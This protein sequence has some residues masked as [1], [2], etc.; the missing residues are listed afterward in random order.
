MGISNQ[1]IGNGYYGGD[2]NGDGKTDV[3]Q[4]WNNNNKMAIFVYNVSSG[5]YN[6][7]Y[8]KTTVH[9]AVH[10]T[11]L[12][13]DVNGDKKTDLIEAWNNGGRLNMILYTSNGSS[14]STGSNITTSNGDVFLKLLP[15]D[16]DGDGRTDIAQLWNNGG[17]LAIIIYKS[18]GSTYSQYW[19]G[20]TTHGTG[21][22]GFTSGDFNGDGRTDITQLFD[23]GGKLSMVV[24]RS[25]GT[26]YELSST[27]V[28]N[29]VRGSG[30]VGFVSLNSDLDGKSDLIQAWN[31]FGE[32]NV[33]LYRATSSGY[34]EVWESEM[35][36]GSTHL[37]LLPYN[38]SGFI[39]VYNNQNKTAFIGYD[40]N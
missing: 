40:L 1:G 6:P 10:I 35:N 34:T 25:L 18:N 9:G 21:N 32:L 38:A 30:N 2:F 20:V 39:Q 27:I 36:Q 12:P 26:S 31:N 16:I 17:R 15:V 22:V 5:S 3:I 29:T 11:C 8:S 7:I 28:T 37:A 23:N 4:T 19:S 13:V 14:Y 33:T 24:H